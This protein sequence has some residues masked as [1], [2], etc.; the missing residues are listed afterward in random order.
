MQIKFY[1]HCL[2]VTL[3]YHNLHGVGLS[4]RNLFGLLESVFSGVQIFGVVQ[5]E[6]KHKHWVLL[7][8]FNSS[9][10]KRACLQ[11]IKGLFSEY[12]NLKVRVWTIKRL[13]DTLNYMI[14]LVSLAETRNFILNGNSKRIFSSIENFNHWDLNNID[15]NRTIKS[16]SLKTQLISLKVFIS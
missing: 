10:T 5:S 15:F 16:A 1:S 8:C 9:R 11:I 12:P 3:P 14:S 2:V 6:G 13:V 4:L 7:V